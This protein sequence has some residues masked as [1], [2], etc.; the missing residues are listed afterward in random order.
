MV[1]ECS[2]YMDIIQTHFRAQTAVVNTKVCPRTLYGL[3]KVEISKKNWQ[4][5]YSS[6]LKFDEMK[7]D[8]QVGIRKRKDVKAP[9][10]KVII[11]AKIIRFGFMRYEDKEQKQ[12]LVE[13]ALK[14]ESNNYV[15][16]CLSFPSFRL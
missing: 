15:S 4:T 12:E 10:L 7:G 5:C 13:I 11:M 9:F 6:K 16:F 1:G 2:I 3:V 14:Y 8:C